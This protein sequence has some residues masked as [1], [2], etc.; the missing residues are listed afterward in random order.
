[1]SI[2]SRVT[3]PKAS[4]PPLQIEDT[5][6]KYSIS[7]VSV[8]GDEIQYGV[9]GHNF[10]AGDIIDIT[11]V[12]DTSGDPMP[13]LEFDNATILSV[14]TNAFTI[15]NG[16]DISSAS[17]FASGNVAKVIGN[18]I[19]RY[20]VVSED[21]NRY[22]S[23]SAQ[24]KI[25]SSGIVVPGYIVQTATAVRSGNTVTISWQDLDEA[26]TGSYDVYASY[27]FSAGGT[28]VGGAEYLATVTGSSF[29][30]VIDLDNNPSAT[31]VQFYIQL[32]TFPKKRVLELTVA[33][34]DIIVI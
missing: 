34:S 28:T 18:Y 11:N 21:R 8:I 25:S 17:G 3:I 13:D 15:A 26:I 9:S 24:H 7:S 31:A 5:L 16:N 32:K 1:M 33:K 4:L 2:I 20:R 22:S 19:I 27:G 23:W 30:A 6:A 14:T 12:L 10:V 29:A